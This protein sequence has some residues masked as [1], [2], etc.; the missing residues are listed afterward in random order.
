MKRLFKFFPVALA[1]VT[2]ASCSSDD[3]Q[4]SQNG[5]DLVLEDGKLYVEVEGNNVTRGGFAS[6]IYENSNGVNT[7][8][9]ALVF[10]EGDRIKVYCDQHNWRTQVWKLGQDQQYL[11]ANGVAS[12]EPEVEGEEKYVKSDE[13]A[14]GIYPYTNVKGTEETDKDAQY[15]WF[16]DEDRSTMEFNFRDQAKITYSAA[17]YDY[18]KTSGGAFTGETVEGTFYKTPFPLWGVKDAGKEIMTMKYL[19]GILRIDYTVTADAEENTKNYLVIVADKQLNGKFVA[20]DVDPAKLGTEAPVLT[21]A[22]EE[23]ITDDDVVMSAD[24]DVVVNA[25]VVDMG[26]TKGHKMVYLPLPAQTYGKLQVYTATSVAANDALSLDDEEGNLDPLYDVIDKDLI[27]TENETQN[28]KVKTAN[29]VNAGVWYRVNDDSGMLD[30]EA[31]SPFQMVQAI[32]AA[33]KEAYRDFTIEFQNP[34]IVDNGDAT[35]QRQWI[36]FQNTVANY[37]LGEAYNLN[38]HVTVK[39]TLKGNAADQI[40]KIKNIGGAKLTLNIEQ[41]DDTPVKIDVAKDLTS[42]L[43]LDGAL[44]EV[45]NA[46]SDKLTIAGNVGT[47]VTTE[48]NIT[49]DAKGKTVADLIISKG[50]TKVNVLDGTVTKVEFTEKTE[51][52]NKQI[53][54]DVELHTEGTGYLAEVDYTNVPQATDGKTFAKTISYTSK[55]DGETS[56]NELTDISG[57]VKGLNVAGDG[58]EA[59]S[60]AITSA[61]QLAGFASGEATRILA[62]EIDVDGKGMQNNA[63]TAVVNGNYNV[64]PTAVTNKADAAAIAQANIKDLQIGATELGTDNYG[65]FK[66]AGTGA[67]V[68][69]LKISDAKI[70]GKTGSIAANIGT[71][72]GYAGADITVQNVDVTGLT[73][74]ITGKTNYAA[75]GKYLN[76][77]GVIG[78]VSGG[79]ATMLDVHSTGAISAN[80]SLGGIIGNVAKAANSK[81]VFGKSKQN[82]TKYSADQECSSTIAMTVTPGQAEY[83]PLYAKVGTLVGSSD[84]DGAGVEIYTKTALTTPSIAVPGKA[85]A[86]QTTSTFAILRYNIERGLDEVG[87]SG[88]KTVIEAMENWKVNVYVLNNATSI[89]AKEYVAKAYTTDAPHTNGWTIAN[90]AAQSPAV[91]C[92]WNISTQYTTSE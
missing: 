72:I 13:I 25:I 55:W 65:L 59:V 4:L 3:L 69:N 42:E 27:N 43:V 1:A 35:P 10:E 86:S 53:A 82:N 6:A 68:Y 74:T 48:G 41:D 54:A 56:Q 90:W 84:F 34:I 32:I 28:A 80:G 16:T 37:G 24:G 91:Y 20:E 76:I 26:A 81:A 29:T 73:A 63:L 75:A 71:L 77:G 44:T 83:D 15:G 92:A 23:A 47:S 33:D 38:H 51:E 18:Q 2:L 57:N 12:F 50:C 60:S 78:Q 19:T 64:Y 39:A 30:T 46:S 79:T 70:I 8:F 49:I 9:N 52:N 5:Q 87:F 36:D 58:I 31:S 22:D 66:T 11:K 21:A 7:L 61:A 40:L 45:T 62:K 85:K 67:K 17:D 88:L 89:T 14:Y